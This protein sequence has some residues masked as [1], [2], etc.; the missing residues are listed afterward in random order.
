MM[1]PA[2]VGGN[3]GMMRSSP[4]PNMNFPGQQGPG[5]GQMLPQGGGMS[6]PQQ[7]PMGGNQSGMGGAGQ[8][9]G[10]HGHHQGPVG[11]GPGDGR[12]LSRQKIQDLVAFVDPNER[13]DPDAE[14]LLM[15]IAED[16]VESVAGFSCRIANHRGSKV[17]EVKDVQLHLEK[18][19]NMRIHGYSDDDVKVNH[20]PPINESHRQRLSAVRRAKK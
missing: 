10:Q 4:G 6:A 1:N 11:M 2:G 17:L 13:L 20:R 18:S 19:W 15:L 9:Q 12:I 5:H 7:S 8:G 3:H 16:F 14:D